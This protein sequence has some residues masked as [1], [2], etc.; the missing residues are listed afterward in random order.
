MAVTLT[1]IRQGLSPLGNK[2]VVEADVQFSN[3]YVVGGE[4]VT[5]ATL[6]LYQVTE[7]E[8]VTAVHPDGATTAG[9]THGRQIVPVVTTVTAPKLKL[10]VSN[11]TESGAVDQTQVISRVRFIGN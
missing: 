3:P 6:G 8:I 1:V 5:L 7:I 4:V 9:N 11:N 10:F 2:R